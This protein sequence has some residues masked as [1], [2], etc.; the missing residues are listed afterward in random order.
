MDNLLKYL[1]D[2]NFKDIIKNKEYDNI[3]INGNYIIHLLAIRGNEEGL[4]FFIDNNINIKKSNSNGSNIIHLLFQNGWDEL[5]HKYY[6]KYPDL[7]F[8]IN[9]DFIYPI[10]LSVSRF[11]IFNKCFKFMLK[12]DD[13]KTYD[14]LNDV[15]KFNNNIFILLIKNS[16]DNKD[17]KYTKF[18]MDN[19]NNIDY[20]KPLYEPILM[21]SIEKNK[22]ILTKYFINNDKGINNKDNM[23]LLP[24]NMAAS[25]NNIE[26]V[27][28]L[29]KKSDINYGGIDNDYLPLSIAI[30]ND[31]IDLA[32]FLID[33]IDNFNTVD[34]HKNIYLHYI[35]NK[36]NEY[37]KNNSKE[38]EK[39]MFNI[40]K[41]IINKSDI[42]F[43]NNY[44]TTPRIILENYIK[45][46]NKKDKDTKNLID[47]INSI[48][49]KDSDSISIDIIKNTKKFNTGL[50]NSDIIHNALYTIYLLNKYDNLVIPIQ[51]YDDDKYNNDC[52]NMLLQNIPYDKMYMIIYDIINLSTNYLYPLLPSIIIWANK[53]LYYIHNDLFNIIKNIHDNNNK[54]FILIKI[55]FVPSDKYT[56][57]NIILIDLKDYTVRRFEP[58]GINNVN[59]EYVLDELLEKNI[60]K[61][62]NKKIKYY[63]PSDYLD[64][65]RFQLVSNDQ[66]LYLRKTGDPG[67]YCLAWC[68]WYIELKINNPDLEEKELINKASKRIEH[69]YRKTE[70]P[71]L[72]FIRDYSRKLSNEKDKIF[73]KIKINRMN[74]YDVSYKTSNLNKIFNY[75]KNYF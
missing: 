69:Y 13:K 58:F 28:L 19:I 3:N 21:Y 20:S 72:Y 67:G 71:Y 68:F 41:K 8:N 17:D 22:N 46:K 26:V 75:I 66:S 44:K 48:E 73:K 64:N 9:N 38:L 59:D 11:D 18:I 7:L 16:Q 65:V 15:S 63:I 5:A 60:S 40:L 45:S 12:Y 36:I 30:N 4:D 55:S 33:Y 24:I 39:R 27:K 54:R 49:D 10:S 2:N 53:D 1:N 25:K 42:D 56:H 52:D 35:S 50:F 23:D 62:L 34:K 47:S 43:V 29:I 32:E 14:V 31:M 37:S 74:Y 51:K 61:I 70:N 57:A 6:I